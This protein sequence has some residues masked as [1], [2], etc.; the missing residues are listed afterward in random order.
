MGTVEEALQAQVRNIEATY[1][2]PIEGWID[3]VRESGKAKHGEIVAM[4]KTEHGLTHGSANRVALIARDALASSGATAADPVDPVDE[5]Y[6]GKKAALRPIHDGLMA[7]LAAL[8]PDLEVA[9]KKGYVSVRRKKQFAMLQPAATHVD[10]GLI[11]KDAP[12]T[13]R[14][15]SAT[16]FNA[17]F[18]HR[19][20]VASLTDI[21]AELRTW[22]QQA[23]DRAT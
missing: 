3:V 8:G 21:D 1:G 12:T 5:L 23:Y 2:R 6:T 13:P 14:L 15:E 20:R 22:L 9:P 18:T 19:V 17:M 7:A 10:V 4:L 11:F 16:T